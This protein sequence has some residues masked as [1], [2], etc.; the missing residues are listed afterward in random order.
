M[1]SRT[2]PA[3][4]D[5]MTSRMTDFSA[6]CIARTFTCTSGPNRRLRVVTQN[7]TPYTRI[8]CGSYRAR[9]AYASHC[10]D[11]G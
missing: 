10:A 3:N 5:S 7:L 9:V 4:D 11:G 6:G 1:K 2:V 8:C